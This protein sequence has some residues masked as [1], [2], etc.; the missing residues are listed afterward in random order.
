MKIPKNPSPQMMRALAAAI[1]ALS[2]AACSKEDEAGRTP[3]KQLDDGIAKVER[4][5]DALRANMEREAAAAALAASAAVRDVKQASLD[6]RE[7]V[8]A[9]LGDAGIVTLVKARLAAD[10]V[11]SAASINVDAS[12]GR[13]VLRGTVAD[14]VAVGR[15]REIALGVKG[16][17]SV[18]NQ[19]TVK[20]KARP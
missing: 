16:V 9:D 19:V 3:G 17:I 13:V 6:I 5:S 18:D 2:L 14:F 15:A 12:Q 7:Q 4:Q 20:P 11:M 8:G 1:I 10:S